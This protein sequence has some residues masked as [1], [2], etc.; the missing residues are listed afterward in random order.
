MQTGAFLQLILTLSAISCRLHHLAQVIRETQD[1]VAGIL[2]DLCNSVEVR[3]YMGTL[4]F[5]WNSFSGVLSSLPLFPQQWTSRQLL[6]S[7]NL[8]SLSWYPLLRQQSKSLRNQLIPE[9]DKNMTRFVDESGK[10]QKCKSI[11]IIPVIDYSLHHKLSLSQ[12]DRLS[13]WRIPLT[14][15][16]RDRTSFQLSGVL[17]RRKSS[18]TT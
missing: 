13:E 4:W 2:T 11:Y 5:L 14:R 7:E 3:F 17:K 6:H 1:E 9:H 16:Y 15:L 18:L 8:L 12:K 10:Q